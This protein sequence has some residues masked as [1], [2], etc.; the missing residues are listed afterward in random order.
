VGFW[1]QAVTNH[2]GSQ[3]EILHLGGAEVGLLI[4]ASPSTVVMNALDNVNEGRRSLLPMYTPLQSTT[5]IIYP[6]DRHAGIIGELRSALALDRTIASGH[7]TPDGPTKLRLL[8]VP[9]AGIA[10]IRIERIGGELLSRLAHEIEGLDSFDLG[11][12]HLDLPLAE[13]S[14]P[15][16][17]TALERLGFC[18]AAWLPSFTPTSDVLRLQH[19]G[20]RPVDIEH[21]ICARA[22]GERIRDYV[23]DDW[24]RVR[25]GGIA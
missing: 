18:F 4:G 16:I 6:P 22:E 10:H 12:I 17:A 19:I 2:V 5:Q 25:R 7:G 21:V 3:K 1:A 8:I 11:V 15:G 20:S 14:A 23:I 13:P 24:H 9:E